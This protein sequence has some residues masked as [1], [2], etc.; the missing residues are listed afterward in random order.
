[1]LLQWRRGVRGLEYCTLYNML[2][3]MSAYHQIEGEELTELL[4]LVQTF[5]IKA[6]RLLVLERLEMQKGIINYE[7]S[8]NNEVQQL[9]NELF[10]KAKHYG[11][12]FKELIDKIDMIVFNYLKKE[13]V[14]NRL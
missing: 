2:K 6:I 12:L 10:G 3:E 1:M 13:I 9:R 8:G 14:E 5:K 7:N 11:G 4:H